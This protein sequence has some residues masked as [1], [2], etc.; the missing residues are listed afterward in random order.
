MIARVSKKFSFKWFIYH[1]FISEFDSQCVLRPVN[2][3]FFNLICSTYPL[4]TI[5]NMHFLPCLF[6][7]PI[8]Y[9]E[10]YILRDAPI[11]LWPTV[12]LQCWSK[13]TKFPLPIGVIC[14]ICSGCM[15][16][17]TIGCNLWPGGKYILVLTV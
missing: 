3:N 9:L 16:F 4:C 14:L 6:Y 5:N 13:I 7:S 17:K 15:Y 10:F 2:K 12:D 11:V 1:F 8:F